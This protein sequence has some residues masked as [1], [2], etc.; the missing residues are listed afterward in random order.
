MVQAT[1]ERSIRATPEQRGEQLRSRFLERYG[2][3]PRVYHAPGRVNLIGEHTD[4]SDGFVMPVALDLFTR[5]AVRPRTDRRIS[6][7]SEAVAGRC[8]FD[9]DQAGEPSR[10]AR[11]DANPAWSRYVQGVAVMIE[12]AGYR[13]RGADVLVSSDVPVGSGLSSSAAL[14]VATAF[15][16][17]AEASG[18]PEAFEMDPSALAKICLRAENE[19]VGVQCGIMDQ[20]A[21]ASCIAHHALL[22]D[23]RS[24]SS[25]NLPIPQDVRIVVANT[26]VRHEHGEGEYNVRCKECADSAR[27]LS[28]ARGTALSL[29]D[30]QPVDLP[31]AGRLLPE[32]LFH[33]VRHVVTENDRVQ[34]SAQ[35]LEAGDVST[36]GTL[37]NE[38]HDSL[39]DDYE[40]SCPE[41]DRMVD[42]ARGM[43]G[44]FGSRMTGG[45]F[46]GCT[47]SLVTADRV[48]GFVR[49]VARG[50]FDSTGIQP[51]MH[52]CTASSGV[53]RIYPAKDERP[54]G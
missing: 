5:V 23:C 31:E 40:V 13:L 16:L 41:L 11:A 33:R 6:A 12:R 32:K 2:E 44:V 7:S 27:I 19:F 28:Q 22:L 26:M 49:S 51:W 34:Q 9:L 10:A 38:S 42:L 15:A 3:E 37:M 21:A 52:V 39:K 30:L 36:F 25:R 4:Y 50:Y 48:E 54:L 53:R 35:A 43:G 45:G 46:G 18:A 1:E 24:L 14:E 17:L 29:R 47:V 8:E 20:M